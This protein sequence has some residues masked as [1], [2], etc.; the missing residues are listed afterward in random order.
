MTSTASL[1][2][3]HASAAD[4]AA[5]TRLAALD[6]SR[7]PNGELLVAELD[8]SLVAALSVDTGAA[9]ADPF[10]HTAA[11]VD[12]LRTQVRQTR[13]PRPAILPGHLGRALFGR[14]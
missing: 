2:I 13:A 1:T 10:E 14:A 4:E 5:L 8:G 11:I 6:S 3:R 9:I 7:V 12:S